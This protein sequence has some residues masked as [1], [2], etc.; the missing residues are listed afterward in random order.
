MWRSSGLGIG[1]PL[2]PWK[3]ASLLTASLGAL[4]RGSAIAS[5]AGQNT[6][7]YQDVFEK[8]V[9]MWVF[10]EKVDGKNLSDIINEKHENVKYLPGVKVHCSLASRAAPAQPFACPESCP[11]TFG[12]YRR[13]KKQPNQRPC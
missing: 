2:R 8:D 12:R 5:I 10:E 1:A 4:C 11:T 7:K 3:L 9:P 13:F 6:S